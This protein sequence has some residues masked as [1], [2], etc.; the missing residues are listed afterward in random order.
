[1]SQGDQQLIRASEHREIVEM[2]EWRF[3][4][5]S[6]RALLAGRLKRGKYP[7][8]FCHRRGV[9][10]HS[11]RSYRGRKPIWTSAFQRT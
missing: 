3:A 8:V 10:C 4:V 5:S 11:G 9:E 1:M 2:I 6:R 7:V